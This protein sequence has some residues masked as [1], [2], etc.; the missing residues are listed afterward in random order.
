[1]AVSTAHTICKKIGVHREISEY[2]HHASSTPRRI[3]NM[4]KNHGGILN[5]FDK[6]WDLETAR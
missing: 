1:M 2:S 5:V 3:L 6:F 4:D